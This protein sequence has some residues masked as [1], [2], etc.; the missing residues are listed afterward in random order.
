MEMQSE[1]DFTPIGLESHKCDPENKRLKKRMSITSTCLTLILD[2]TDGIID[3]NYP[4]S[5]EV[6]LTL[7]NVLIA[8]DDDVASANN[9]PI[10]FC[11]LGEL[12]SHTALNGNLNSNQVLTL[13]NDPSIQTTLYSPQIP[14]GI[15]KSIPTRITYKLSKQDGTILVGLNTVILQFA[16][17]YLVKK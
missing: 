9:G 2:A 17:S 10:I 12:T 4:V 16:Y 5:D 15:D 8:F 1:G 13:T 7:T 14:V 6:V 3:L 11:D